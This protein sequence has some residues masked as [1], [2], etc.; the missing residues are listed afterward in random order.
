MIDPRHV[1]GPIRAETRRTVGPRSCLLILAGGRRLLRSIRHGGLPL[2]Y[3][4]V[5]RRSTP[6]T[7][8]NSAASVAEESSCNEMLGNATACPSSVRPLLPQSLLYPFP[9]SSGLACDNQYSRAARRRH[10]RPRVTIVTASFGVQRL[11]RRR[12]VRRRDHP[13]VEHRRF[14][15]SCVRST[16]LSST[17]AKQAESRMAQTTPF[18]GLDA[19]QRKPRAAALPGADA[20]MAQ[21]P[22]RT[23]E[24]QF[25][26][27]D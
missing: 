9:D 17:Y 22:D 10:Y 1:T 20:E 12:S 26:D 2:V 11:F 3:L 6:S 15:D 8:V 18:G 21:R 23:C 14:D 27:G 19:D 5:V 7:P 13:R 24:I 4:S 16:V 25:G